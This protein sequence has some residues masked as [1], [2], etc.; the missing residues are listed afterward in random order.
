MYWKDEH[1]KDAAAQPLSQHTNHTDS[2]VDF[3]IMDLF[4]MGHFSKSACKTS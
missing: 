3:V 2:L 4:E 1:R